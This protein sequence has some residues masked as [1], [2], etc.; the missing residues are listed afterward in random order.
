M[1]WYMTY[2]CMALIHDEMNH[3]SSINKHTFLRNY[4]LHSPKVLVL[5]SLLKSHLKNG[6]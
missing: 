4:V 6:V 2:V 3:C 1:C 5:V